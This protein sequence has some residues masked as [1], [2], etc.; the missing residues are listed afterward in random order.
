MNLKMLGN[1]TVESPAFTR[2]KSKA[3]YSGTTKNS[4]LLMNS[5]VQNDTVL[6]ERD[7]VMLYFM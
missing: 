4:L 1:I 3:K 5:S 2:K 7:W 6:K